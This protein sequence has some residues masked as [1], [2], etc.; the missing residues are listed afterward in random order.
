MRYQSHKYISLHDLASVIEKTPRCEPPMNRVPTW[1]ALNRIAAHDIIT[2]MDVPHRARAAYDGFAVHSM[3]TPGKLRLMGSVRVGEIPAFGVDRGEAVYVTTGAYL[4]DGV[5][6]VVPE[7][8]AELIDD[9]VLVANKVMSGANIDPIG[10]YLA[11]GSKVI[12][13]GDVIMGHVIPALL[14]AGIMEVDVYERPTISII[15]TGN[16]LVKPTNASDAVQAFLAGK[17]VESTG[18]LISWF[19]ESYMPYLSIIE[20]RLV[21]DD[22]ESI[23]SIMLDALRKSN[24]LIT[25]GGSGP[26]DIDYIEEA[27]SSLGPKWMIR[28]LKMRPGRP[29]T[30]AAMDGCKLIFGLSGHPISALNALIN[31]IEPMVKIMLGIRRSPAKPIVKGR[32][33]RG[34]AVEPGIITQIRVK[35]TRGN[36]ELLVTPLGGGSSVTTSLAAT[37]GLITLT[38]SL[39][40]GDIVDVFMMRDPGDA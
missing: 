4:P 28:G 30:V 8:E 9:Q 31:V 16:E 36:G 29:T 7:E 24:I 15:S 35:V 27:T 18:S 33:T 26:S 37:D 32:L 2:T 12:G 13:K 6:A 23:R 10:S 11:S 3:D 38:S 22:P 1:S 25:T 21:N 14:E 39:R 20:H 5:D 19:I 40:E 34:I 17:T